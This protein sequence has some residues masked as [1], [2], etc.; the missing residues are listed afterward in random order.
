M[1]STLKYLLSLG[2][3]SEV[4]PSGEGIG[5][6][7][8]KVRN[9]AGVQIP[10]PPFT[11]LILPGEVIQMTGS[12]SN[13]SKAVKGGVS[14]AELLQLVFIVLK[15]CKVITWNWFWVLSPTLIPL[16]LLIIIMIIYFICRFASKKMRND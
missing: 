11:K 10:P 13:G 1:Y 12:G 8:R 4:Y 5:P 15:L 16:I 14:F 3:H 6:E 9:G 7:N 2:V